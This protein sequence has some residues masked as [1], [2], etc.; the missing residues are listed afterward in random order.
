MRYAWAPTERRWSVGRVGIILGE[1]D[2][3]ISSMHLARSRPREDALMILA[4]DDDV[5]EAVSEAIRSLEAI[6][7]VW[8]I[9]LGGTH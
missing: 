3:N 8:I 1:T 2:V 6:R 5:P 7:D 9:R 4:V